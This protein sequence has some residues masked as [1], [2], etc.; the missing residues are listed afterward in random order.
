MKKRQAQGAVL[1]LSSAPGCG[2]LMLGL[3]LLFATGFVVWLELAGSTPVSGT[4]VGLMLGLGLPA[5]A[6]TALG[7]HRSSVTLDRE[8]RT[9]TRWHSIFVPFARRTESIA[10]VS[11]VQIEARRSGRH[12][13]YSVRLLGGQQVVT[14]LEQ[15]LEKE[16]RRDAEAI[17]EHL[18]LRLTGR[19]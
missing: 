8:Q 16:A 19:A 3:P 4:G 13:S 7:F 11:A 12:C 9:L 2:L 5:V 15:G 17:A 18:G 6:F 1:R 14:V 10:E